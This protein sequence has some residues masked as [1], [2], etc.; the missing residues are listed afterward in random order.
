[1]KHERLH[2]LVDGIFAIGMTLLVLELRVPD[3]GK[4]ATDAQLTTAL[5]DLLPSFYAFILSFLLLFIFWR[6]YNAIVSGLAKNIDFTI[7]LRVIFFLLLISLIP[8][9]TYFFGRYYYSQIGVSVYA[10]NILLVSLSLHHLRKYILRADHIETHGWSQ[11][12]HRN[13]SIRSLTP[14]TIAL[15]SIPLSHYHPNVA[16]ALLLSIVLVN[17]FNKSFDP[18]FLLLDKMGIGLDEGDEFHPNNRKAL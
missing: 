6:G 2:A 8:F 3:L 12:D 4:A 7:V 15:L 16:S 17:I 5:R 18:V 11:R 14:A 10:I 1:M 9:S 13:A